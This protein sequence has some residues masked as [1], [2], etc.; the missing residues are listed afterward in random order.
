MWDFAPAEQRARDGS[1]ALLRN[2]MVRGCW[3]GSAAGKV[4][5]VRTR[6]LA[7][8]LTHQGALSRSP[9]RRQRTT[10]CCGGSRSWAAFQLR[11]G[12]ERG[13]SPHGWPVTLNFATR[14]V[15]KA[16]DVASAA[17]DRRGSRAFF[18]SAAPGR[19]GRGWQDERQ[20]CTRAE[21][22]AVPTETKTTIGRRGATAANSVKTVFRGTCPCERD[23]VSG[24]KQR[25]RWDQQAES[26]RRER[27]PGAGRE[28]S[29]RGVED[30][31][32]SLGGGRRRP[33]RSARRATSK[34][35]G[36]GKLTFTPTRGCS[37][38]KKPTSTPTRLRV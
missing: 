16:L 12:R 6:S 4:G 9:S 14:D 22:V 19:A 18:D 37:R 8:A 36:R 38:I 23:S 13:S 21:E 34:S 31:P 2:S 32:G 10:A 27:L 25:S 3:P 26:A 5:S 7:P 28:A 11:I 15:Q 24:A 30:G 20:T 33:K 35:E 17:P 1:S 29:S